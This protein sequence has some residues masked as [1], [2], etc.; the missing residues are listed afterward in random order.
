M[1]NKSSNRINTKKVIFIS[2]IIV[3]VI[4]ICIFSIFLIMRNKKD[5][6]AKKMDVLG[7][8]RLYSNLSKNN[9]TKLDALKIIV[10]A[11]SN[12]SYIDNISLQQIDD[13]N[14]KWLEYAKRKSLDV[15]QI[16]D[17]SNLNENIKE[18][19]FL[20]LLESARL[21]MFG[22]KSIPS[23]TIKIDNPDQYSI[24]ILSAISTFVN[25]GIVNRNEN[26][27][28]NLTRNNLNKII[29][30]Y[31]YKYN[32]L[33]ENDNQTLL[34]ETEIDSKLPYLISE[35]DSKF[36][37]YPLKFTYGKNYKSPIK[38]YVDIRGDYRQLFN[39]IHDYFDNILNLDYEK[40]DEENL[41]DA[42]AFNSYCESNIINDY[43]ESIKKNNLKVNGN[44]E[45]IEPVIYTDNDYI[46]VRIKLN[47]VI[48]N[49]SNLSNCLFGDDNNNY[50][51]NKEYEIIYD[52]KLK[53]EDGH[54]Y[55]VDNNL[56]N[57]KVS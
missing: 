4:T 19:E 13:E 26:F 47:F 25:E 53:K 21:N 49:T 20:F 6:Y 12:N 23:S 5:Y 9:V 37:N 31:I 28:A 33:V 35:I 43:I 40:L 57:L 44:C 24:P 32:I 14:E 52:V 18:E 8:S 45:I 56:N 55:I 7:Y 17:S 15:S 46:Y 38:S 29:I 11:N 48:N 36:Y 10:A 34:A 30:K 16:V 51:L 39:T 50:E 3:I 2:L 1:K 41:Y 22:D 42:I 54:F 27:K